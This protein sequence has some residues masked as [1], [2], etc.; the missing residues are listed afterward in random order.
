MTAQNVAEHCSL[1][2]MIMFQYL[3]KFRTNDF[4]HNNLKFDRHFPYLNTLEVI[5]YESNI[6]F[7]T[8]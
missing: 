8:S 1:H 7:D 6:Y 2:N 3:F 5:N 4:K